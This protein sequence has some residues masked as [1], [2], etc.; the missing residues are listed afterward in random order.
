VVESATMDGM[1]I[2]GIAIGVATLILV[3]I[4]LIWGTGL[5]RHREKVEIRVISLDYIVYA[6]GR[7]FGLHPHIEL[8]RSGGKDT[9]CV[10]ALY[11]MPLDEQ[12]YSELSKH[13]KLPE[14]GQIAV[15]SRTELPRD[16][17]VEFTGGR[18]TFPSLRASENHQALSYV[19]QIVT[20]YG[21]KDH[22]IAIRWED[23]D[24]VTWKTIPEG[25]FRMWV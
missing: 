23:T 4:S 12:T 20:L 3:T 24:K 11:V 19:K 2:A 9:R 16:K 21:E 7:H 6:N 13:F 18:I 22:K 10:R 25:K 5:W 1:T 15:F 14:D 8:R 17:I